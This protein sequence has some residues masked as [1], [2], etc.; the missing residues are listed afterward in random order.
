MHFESGLFVD[1]SSRDSCMCQIE[2]LHEEVVEVLGAARV[3]VPV[4]VV[5]SE[6]LVVTV[7]CQILERDCE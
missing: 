5:E 1:E 7:V 3:L 4:L 2:V 6:Q